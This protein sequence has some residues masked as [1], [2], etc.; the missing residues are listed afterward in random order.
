MFYHR[1][2]DH[3]VDELQMAHDDVLTLCVLSLA[4]DCLTEYISYHEYT[5][6]SRIRLL[7]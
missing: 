5:A 3:L 4:A 2:S 1:A 7:P 6:M